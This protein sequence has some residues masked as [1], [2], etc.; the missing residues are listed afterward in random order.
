MAHASV[1]DEWSTLLTTGWQAAQAAGE[2]ATALRIAVELGELSRQMG[3]LAEAEAW[4]AQAWALHQ[5]HDDLALLGRI[6]HRRAYL[7]S[8]R[9][10]REEAL[11]LAE[12]AVRLLAPDTDE[13]AM[14]QF[15]LG[16]VLDESSPSSQALT[17][18]RNHFHAALAVWQRLGDLRWSAKSIQNLGRLSRIEGD[19]ISAKILLLH[20]LDL[21][22]GV[23]D[24]WSEASI[25]I[26]LGNV[27]LATKEYQT[28]LDQYAYALR[29]MRSVPD[30]RHIAIVLNN[31]GM[32][33]A[34]QGHFDDAETYYLDSINYWSHAG[35]T[36]SRINV[37]DNLGLLYMLTGALRAAMSVFEAALVEL[38]VYR[39]PDAKLLQEEIESHF[40]DAKSR[41]LNLDTPPSGSST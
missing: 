39:D 16:V 20:A 14:A 37:E 32:I 27:Y 11:A 29:H 28:A 36:K 38:A 17:R 7:F 23:N 25:Q 24:H 34:A 33:L 41:L 5:P 15:T 22:S 10:D 35:D 8:Q 13:W 40:L 4:L 18:I 30:V 6:L 9:G 26:S 2:L 21:L 19:A 1:R 31:I 12:E 3:K